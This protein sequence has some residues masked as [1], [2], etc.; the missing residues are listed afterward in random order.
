VT[1]SLDL[2]TLGEAM[3]Q[4]NATEVGL[5]RH[6]RTFEKHAAGSELNCAIAASRLGLRTGWI[7]KLGRDE[8]G[9]FVLASARSERVDTSAVVRDDE[10]PTGLFLIQRGYPLPESSSSIYYRNGS[11]GSRLRT[12]ELS[13]AY[14]SRARIFHFSGISLAV[15]QELR[16]TCWSAVEM[17]KSAGNM[18]S[19]DIN[20][21]RKLWGPEEGKAVIEEAL[22]VADVVFCG[23]D[24]AATLFGVDTPEEA[25]TV[26]ASYGPTRVVVTRGADGALMLFDGRTFEGRGRRVSVV[27]ATGAGDAL[28]ATVLT[29]ILGGWPDDRT[30]DLACIVGSLVCSVVGDFEGVPSGEQLQALYE[31]SWVPR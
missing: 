27:D 21:R 30:I 22:S 31:D 15:S 24:D 17:A 8:L 19:F 4:L 1:S 13:Q 16:R 2:V 14:V 18:I 20:F 7:G 28:A 12:S 11:A 9:E 26:L 5:L 25:L 29:G 10:V 23:S 3:V 6:V